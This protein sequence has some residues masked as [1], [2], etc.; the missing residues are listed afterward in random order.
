[1]KLIDDIQVLVTLDELE[2]MWHNAYQSGKQEDFYYSI[3]FRGYMG[4]QGIYLPEPLKK[5]PQSTD[6]DLPF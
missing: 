5:E 4:E 6:D 1:M 3:T 2:E